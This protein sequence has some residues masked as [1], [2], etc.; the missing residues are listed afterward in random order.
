MEYTRVFH[1]SKMYDGLVLIKVPIQVGT[2][3]KVPSDPPK[4]PLGS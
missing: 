2:A 1:A 4:P 3:G